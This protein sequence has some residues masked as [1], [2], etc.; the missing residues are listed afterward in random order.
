VAVTKLN[1]PGKKKESS[2]NMKT[3]T[4]Q[5]SNSMS[6]SSR[7][8]R[9]VARLLI[10]LLF[11]CFACLPSTQAVTPAPDGAYPG[12][13]TAE[14]L[15]ALAP[16]VPGIW[17][18]AIGGYALANSAPGGLGNTAVG[19]NSL[20][21]NT[22]GTFNSALGVNSLLFNSIGSQN[23]AVGYQV[24]DFNTTATRNTGV[25]FNALFTNNANDNT[26]VG[27]RAL[28]H[29]TTGSNNTATGSQALQ[30]NG[31]GS[32]NVATGY[33]ALNSNTGD[34]NTANGFQ[35]LLHNTIGSGNTAIGPG[36][37][38]F[39]IG[40]GSNTAVGAGF[41]L[42]NNSTGSYNTAIGDFTL[43]NNIAGSFN[44]AIGNGALYNSHGDANT[45]LGINAGQGVST[46]NNVICIGAIGA[47]VPNS[48]YIGNIFGQAIDPAT[49]VTVQVDT[50]GKLGNLV[51]SRR[52]KH[53]IKPMD[54]SSEAILALKPV[55]FHYKSDA[56]GTPQFGLI[57]EEVA[58]AN[59]NLVVRNKNGE[60][61]TVRYE[62]VNAML[63]NE[64]LKEHRRV[65]EQ[66][67]KLQQQEETIAQLKKDFRTTVAELN[68]R[69]KKQD[70]KIE[71]VSTQLEVR[72]PATQIVLNN[73]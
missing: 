11:V 51:S 4:P 72:K 62:A 63:L 18:T 17:N 31:N 21:H 36:A 2:A 65:S 5:I 68:A 39:N 43:S 38:F 24:L 35:A 64:F 58:E 37:L 32:N 3:T 55:T 53:D 23:V 41:V 22:T 47:N 27:W 6:H 60:I 49:A 56:K 13:N 10:P 46:V 66:D 12:Y 48:C 61:F 20:R 54:K 15:N 70:S 67:R 73:P 42:F 25:G 44:T 57:A 34:Y 50:N 40:G 16:A 59:P 30:S 29:N 1:P 8:C 33:Q 71:K 19:L 69:L 9:P 45:A 52:F 14:G 26:A 7:D 28:F